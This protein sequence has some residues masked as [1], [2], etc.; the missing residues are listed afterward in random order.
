MARVKIYTISSQTHTAFRILKIVTLV[1][2]LLKPLI[3][4]LVVFTEILRI[5]IATSHST[6]V[7]RW[8]MA[9]GQWCFFPI[10]QSISKI[11][12]VVRE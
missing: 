10:H 11:S 5:F 1:L 9:N 8:E 12:E 4:I 3:K 2:I 6:F 7:E